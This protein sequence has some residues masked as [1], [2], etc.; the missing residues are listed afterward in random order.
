MLNP[1]VVYY[2]TVG[3]I[4]HNRYR[5][6][7]VLGSG[8]FGQTY[9]AED[10]LDPTRAHCAIKHYLSSPHYPHLRK[11]NQRLFQTEVTQL[12]RLG[13]HPQIPQLLN[14]FEENHGFYLVQDYIKGTALTQEL[15]HSRHNRPEER[16][17]RVVYLLWDL[18]GILAFVHDHGVV[19]CDLK[20]SKLLQRHRD[21]KLV[22]L[23]FGAAQLLDTAVE[24]GGAGDYAGRSTNGNRRWLPFTTDPTQSTGYLAPEQLRGQ[25]Y[26][27]SDLYSVG[28]LALQL[29]T[30]LELH[31]LGIDCQTGELLPIAWQGM[32]PA[33]D[34][35]PQLQA[36]LT[37][38]IR[39]NHQ[40][41]YQSAA[42]VLTDLAEIRDRVYSTLLAESTP[43]EQP[44]AELLPLPLPQLW[45]EE[46]L[47]GETEPDVLPVTIEP[48]PAIPVDQMTVGQAQSAIV[49]PELIQLDT[50]RCAEA[51]VETVQVAPS[52]P[53]DDYAPSTPPALPPAETLLKPR[54]TVVPLLQ[55]QWHQS[56]W[57][58]LARMG[59]VVG[60][61]NVLAITLGMYSIS[62]RM[63]RDPGEPAW[64]AAQDA[65]ETG[66]LEAAIA[67]AETVPQNSV[68]YAESQT[69]LNT[70]QQ[71]WQQAARQFQTIQQA[72]QQQ[73]WQTVLRE[74]AALPQIPYWQERAQPLV[75]QARPQA[76]TQA[77]QLLALAFRKAHQ[78]EFNQALGYLYQIAPQTQVGATLAPKLREYHQKQGIRAMRQLQ[79]AYNLAAKRYFNEA[80]AILQ[81][82]PPNTPAGE[83]AQRKVQEYHQKAQ[84]REQVL[85]RR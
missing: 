53:W 6:L 19:H 23:D 76:E 35:F 25:A 3:E 7:Q 68:R 62:Q 46:E 21:G 60:G 4:L 13:I 37:R 70:W 39:Y 24:K 80:I 44:E 83:I 45:L 56:R 58:F 84:L 66:D 54:A 71:D 29:L 28:V 50:E 9:L 32:T 38:M 1:A 51:V 72:T 30:G 65:L 11:T 48:L 49:E 12:A 15:A 57:Q 79:I 42:E 52:R 20:A 2:P 10:T 26:P 17:A 36:I 18:L 74:A 41:R 82:I 81:E 59:L 77:R 16:A 64:Q 47:D 22:L 34:Y 75:D 5:L 33:P 69:A 14:Q 40:L 78:Q 73:Q 8:A 85:A 31:Q 61:L 55:Y 67:Q 43:E 63:A 27:S